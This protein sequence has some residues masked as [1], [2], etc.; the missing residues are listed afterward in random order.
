MN[1]KDSSPTAGSPEGGYG[2]P[3]PEDELPGSATTTTEAAAPEALDGQKGKSRDG[4]KS[5]DP[6]LKPLLPSETDP[7]RTGVAEEN[8]ENASILEPPD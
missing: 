1:T 2:S 7:Q 4:E 8:L 3:N 6:L 5:T